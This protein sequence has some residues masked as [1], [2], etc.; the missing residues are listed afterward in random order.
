MKGTYYVKSIEEF[1]LKKAVD[2]YKVISLGMEKLNIKWYFGLYTSLRLNGL[3]HEFFDT[4]FVLNSEIF[5]PKEIKI[6]G[7]KVKFIKLRLRLFDFGIIEKDKIKF[8][9]SEKTVLDFIYLFRYRSVTEERIISMVKG[10]EKNLKKRR[11]KE[12]LNFYPK[13]VSRVVENANLV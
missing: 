5:R 3:T 4:I 6:A 13:T 11:L 8:S 2:I 10:Y 1:K 9:D 7:E 12:Y